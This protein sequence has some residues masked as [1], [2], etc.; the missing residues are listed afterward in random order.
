M[1]IDGRVF[2]LDLIISDHDDITRVKDVLVNLLAVDISPVGTAKILYMCSIEI[3]DDS[4]VALADGFIIDFHLDIV[5]P[6]NRQ[7]T[8]IQLDFLDKCLIM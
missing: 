1:A 5:T 2:N 7:Y 3:T 8:S 4:G 6:A